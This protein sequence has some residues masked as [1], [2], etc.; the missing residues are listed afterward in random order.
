MAQ[1]S[2]ALGTYLGFSRDPSWNPGFNMRIQEGRGRVTDKASAGARRLLAGGAPRQ[3]PL[4][5]C[6]RQV[7]PRRVHPSALRSYEQQRLAQYGR[8]RPKAPFGLG[9][10]PRGHFV[11]RR[12]RPPDTRPR[13]RDGPRPLQ[14]FTM[15][16]TGASYQHP[17]SRARRPST[18]GVR[19]V[20]VPSIA[21]GILTLVVSVPLVSRM[22]K[23]HVVQ[24]VAPRA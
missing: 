13:R 11:D 23:K 5:A 15:V 6:P 9:R 3:A 10:W 22:E 19:T 2:R 18:V 14:M 12:P 7:H 16:R 24:H 17:G 8:P 4:G 21:P 20:D 1:Q